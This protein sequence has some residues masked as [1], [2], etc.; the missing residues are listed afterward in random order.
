MSWAESKEAGT[1]AGLHGGKTF[2]ASFC[3]CLIAGS[4]GAFLSVYC[5]C[6][7]VAG[8]LS[9]MHKVPKFAPCKAFL[10]DMFAFFRRLKI[11]LDTEQPM[12]KEKRSFRQSEVE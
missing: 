11:T 12:L 8:V 1:E 5:V 10:F 9:E 6:L 7:F 3:A 2:C 4:R